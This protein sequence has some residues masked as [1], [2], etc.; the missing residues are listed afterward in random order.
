M[1]FFMTN[2]YS[3]CI[4]DKWILPGSCWHGHK[5]SSIFIKP[6]A[7][8]TCYLI[9]PMGKFAIIP[10]P[11]LIFSVV[12]TSVIFLL[13]LSAVQNAETSTNIDILGGV[14]PLYYYT[15]TQML[16]AEHWDPKASYRERFMACGYSAYWLQY[17]GQYLQTVPVWGRD[18]M[19]IS[20]GSAEY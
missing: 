1:I 17:V 16:Q 19:L 15:H 20:G 4:L 13:N 12:K 10:R 6:H 18:H 5:I 9:T 3:K 8:H 14:W 11:A 7:W 2:K